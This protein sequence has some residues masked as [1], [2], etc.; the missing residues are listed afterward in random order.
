M[1]IET[2]RPNIDSGH[3]GGY[4]GHPS[5][6]ESGTELNAAYSLFSKV[7]T[8]ADRLLIVRH[9]DDQQIYGIELHYRPLFGRVSTTGNENKG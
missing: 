9:P 4:L 3:G 5:M 7:L 6:T 1:G 8:R 2:H